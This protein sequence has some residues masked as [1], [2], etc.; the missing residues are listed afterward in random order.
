MRKVSRVGVWDV[1]SG[2]S[3]LGLIREAVTGS[4]PRANSRH[5]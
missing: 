3:D 2:E 1:L 5:K 4:L